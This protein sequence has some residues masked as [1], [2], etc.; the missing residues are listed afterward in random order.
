M[1]PKT[2]KITWATI[3]L[4]IAAA[5]VA[6]IT[7]LTGGCAFAIDGRVASWSAIPGKVPPNVPAW[8]TPANSH[9]TTKP[10]D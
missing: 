1:T 8:A 7:A 6:F 9:P 2:K 4:A 10:S 5:I 3:A